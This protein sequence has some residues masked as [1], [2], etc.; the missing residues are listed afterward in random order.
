MDIKLLFP[1]PLI[2]LDLQNG[3]LVSQL[4][5]AILE[6]EA[7]T[8]GALHSNDGGWQSA[9]DFAAW[10]GDAGATLV[11]AVREAV[12]RLTGYFDGAALTR[13]EVDWRLQAWAN[14]NRAGSANHSHFHPGAFWSACFYVDDG[15]IDGGDAL[16]GAIEFTDPRGALPM[17][18]AP[19]L[20]ML[21]SNCLTAGLGERVYPKTGTLLIFPA[22]LNHSVTRYT[23]TEARI[24]VTVNFCL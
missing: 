11:A 12:N 20:K 1:T 8:T 18:Y 3:E 24:S 2:Q 6:R 14:I 22:W 4:R 9:D 23:G 15:G 10:S 19:K 21:A 13:A 16:G 17:M 5:R 7:T